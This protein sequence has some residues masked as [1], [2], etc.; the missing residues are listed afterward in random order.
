MFN[1]VLFGYRASD[2]A[3]YVLFSL[4]T[5]CGAEGESKKLAEFV[6]GSHKLVHSLVAEKRLKQ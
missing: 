6:R 5:L 3:L 1:F 4:C 2:L